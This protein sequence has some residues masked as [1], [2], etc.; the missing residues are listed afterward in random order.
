MVQCIIAG[1]GSI[2]FHLVADVESEGPQ[3][4]F[5]D[6]LILAGHF[7]PCHLPLHLR[8]RSCSAGSVAMDPSHLR[9]HLFGLDLGRAKLQRTG[10]N[11]SH[12]G[13]LG[14][15][16]RRFSRRGSL[17]PG[18]VLGTFGFAV[19]APLSVGRSVALLLQGLG[20]EIDGCVQR[21]GRPP[22]AQTPPML[23]H[24][25]RPRPALERSPRTACALRYLA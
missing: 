8:P 3:F 21:G 25:Y 7:V 9:E 1:L 20:E 16:T 18:K 5:Q 23:S 15:L 14:G 17:K 11:P 6:R 22:C 10:S 24:G 19:F 4:V 13:K 12:L 2:V